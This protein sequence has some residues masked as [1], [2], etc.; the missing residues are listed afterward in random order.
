MGLDSIRYPF[1]VTTSRPDIA[2][3]LLPDYTSIR[4]ESALFSKRPD[5]FM[6]ARV[7]RFGVF[8]AVRMLLNALAILYILKSSR[9][10][11]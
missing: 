1:G 6:R 9:Y 7:V 4:W 3:N 5:L 11:R 8:Y 2:V 10:T